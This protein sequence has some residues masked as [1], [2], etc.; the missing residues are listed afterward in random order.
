[1][2]S[3]DLHSAVGILLAKRTA[4]FFRHRRKLRTFCLSVRGFVNSS[5]REALAFDALQGNCRTFSI[6]SLASIPLKV[7]LDKVAVQ[8]GFAN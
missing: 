2:G 3:E 8:M 4:R 6:G 5:V 1:M 7:P